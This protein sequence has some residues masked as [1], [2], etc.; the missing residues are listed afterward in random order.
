MT[1]YEFSS[2]V[3][4]LIYVKFV[5]DKYDVNPNAYCKK[6]LYNNLSKVLSD[7]PDNHTLKLCLTVKK[8]CNGNTDLK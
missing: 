5:K 1:K 7:T 6:Y 2:I 3:N 8:Q 4:L